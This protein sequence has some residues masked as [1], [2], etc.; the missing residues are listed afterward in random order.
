MDVVIVITNGPLWILTP[1]RPLMNNTHVGAEQY[2]KAV[3]RYDYPRT[4][5]NGPPCLSLAQTGQ[6]CGIEG[7][8]IDMA[9]VISPCDTDRVEPSGRAEVGRGKR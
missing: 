1:K 8:S 4:E 2:A 6:H 7:V 5:S 3:H 9:S